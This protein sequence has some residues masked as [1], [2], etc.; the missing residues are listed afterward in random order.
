MFPDTQ[1]IAQKLPVNQSYTEFFIRMHSKI[2]HNEQKLCR[3]TSV[4]LERILNLIRVVIIWHI[5]TI[6]KK[7]KV[8]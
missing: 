2:N 3:N 4:N 6:P 5:Q 1:A 8:Q 7:A